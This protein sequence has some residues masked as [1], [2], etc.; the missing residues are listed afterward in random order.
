MFLAGT[1]GQLVAVAIAA[2]FGAL[3]WTQGNVRLSALISAGAFG[4]ALIMRLF[5]TSTHPERAWYDGRALAES[6]KTL[7]WRYCVG[8]E[9][10]GLSAGNA[11][12]L[13]SKRTA[14]VM[15]LFPDLGLRTAS[16]TPQI[17]SS[18]RTM[19][20][21]S[22]DDRRGAYEAGRIVDQQRWYSGKADW[23][24]RRARAWA[25]VVLAAECL[26]LGF[27]LLRAGGVVE[28]DGLGVIAAIAAGAAAWLQVKQHDAL[29]RAYA[30]AAQE[31]ANVRSQIGGQADE[32]TWARFVDEAEEAVS[33]EHT[34]WRA[35]RGVRGDLGRLTRP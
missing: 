4:I 31:L 2:L 1:G 16:I 20:S 18:M 32:T 33:R 35:S 11:D 3:S 13:F 8:G 21:E 17:T 5:L 22:L 10:F 14:E 29:S 30:V 23:N 27:A 6:M 15:G 25:G 34:P 7:S 28:I 12:E 24:R 26:G 19:R 9:P